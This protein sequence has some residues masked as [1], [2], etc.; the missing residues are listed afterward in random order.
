MRGHRNARRAGGLQNVQNVLPTRLS[1]HFLAPSEATPEMSPQ[2][3]SALPK[4]AHT[5]PAFGAF[6]VSSASSGFVQCHSG[7][8]GGQCQSVC[9]PRCWGTESLPL[10]LLL[11]RGGPGL[12]GQGLNQPK[13]CCKPHP[14][15]QQRGDSPETCSS[16][17]SSGE[18]WKSITRLEGGTRLLLT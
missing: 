17:S 12:D 7:K 10:V 8:G 3:L 16:H 15:L 18:H 11:A 9:Q 13:V 6:C 1:F 5:T 2:P 14:Q 4:H